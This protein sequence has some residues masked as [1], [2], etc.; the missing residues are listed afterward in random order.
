MRHLPLVE[1][2]L[3]DR[4]LGEPRASRG[5]EVVDVDERRPLMASMVLT[6]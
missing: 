2:G 6:L 3:S 5:E 1:A 4:R